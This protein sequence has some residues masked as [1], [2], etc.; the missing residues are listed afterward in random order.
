M[1]YDV[2]EVST[3]THKI[4]SVIAQQKT[5][6]NAEAIVEMAVIRRGVKN[7][8]YAVVESGKRKEGDDW[9]DGRAN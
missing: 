8:F 5:K 1:M 2:V 3:D 6:K 9:F 7:S 4:L